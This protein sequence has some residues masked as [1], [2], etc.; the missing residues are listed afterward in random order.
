MRA[1]AGWEGEDEGEQSGCF[2]S[3]INSLEN[4]PG[5]RLPS[6]VLF[7]RSLE[8]RRASW[9]IHEGAPSEEFLDALDWLC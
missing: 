4:Q 7:P 6:N 8:L 1:G 3:V 2:C 9:G 5:Q